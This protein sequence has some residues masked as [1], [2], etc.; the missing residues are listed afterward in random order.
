MKFKAKRRHPDGAAMRRR[1]NLV[2]M[3]IQ[4]LTGM[5][6]EVV[7][8]SLVA[9]QAIIEV[10]NC[11]RVVALRSEDIGQ[12]C[13]ENHRKYKQKRAHVC[14]CNVIWSETV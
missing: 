12:D 13:T 10:S 3:A 5:G 2:C 6:I 1:A 7:G 14:G 8:V 9:E 4:T 11:P